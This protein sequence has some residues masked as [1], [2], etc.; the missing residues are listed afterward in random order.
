MINVLNGLNFVYGLISNSLT[1]SMCCR[2]RLRQIATFIIFAFLAIS[3]LLGLFGYPL[4]SF[5]HNIVG[6]NLKHSSSIWCKLIVTL[7]AF[8]YEWTIWLLVLVLFFFLVYLVYQIMTVWIYLLVKYSR[9]LN[10]EYSRTLFSFI[11]RTFFRKPF[12][13]L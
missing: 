4:H 5:L 11:M 9:L 12:I 10:E 13:S 7:T 1:V 3:N 6:V 8:T 2:R